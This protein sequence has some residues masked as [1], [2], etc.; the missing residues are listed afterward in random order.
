[1]V[2]P[3]LI[4][5]DALKFPHLDQ[6]TSAATSATIAVTTRS[7]PQSPDLAESLLPPSL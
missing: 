5:S 1:M 6:P 2:A 4:L 7:E 3:V